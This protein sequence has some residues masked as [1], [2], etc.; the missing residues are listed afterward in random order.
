MKRSSIFFFFTVYVCEKEFEEYGIFVCLCIV[1]RVYYEMEHYW[2]FWILTVLT[3]V[4]AIWC[5][6]LLLH[7]LQGSKLSV[8]YFWG[9]RWAA[10]VAANNFPSLQ[11]NWC[12]HKIS[13]SPL[14]KNFFYRTPSW[15]LCGKVHVVK[16]VFWLLS[17][18][19]ESIS[20]IGL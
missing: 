6:A 15:V 19:Y 3:T 13:V 2:P 10:W 17:Y 1:C 12:I 16:S 4:S 5:L 18:E 8:S 11:E 20:C 7:R 9:W 14:K